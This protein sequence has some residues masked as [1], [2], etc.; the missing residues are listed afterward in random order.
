M[1][2]TK[3]NTSYQYLK[4]NDG[5]EIFAMVRELD[6][7]LELTFPMNIMCKPA[8]TGG[9][10]IHLGPFVPFTTDDTMM[11]NSNDVVVRTSITK[12]FISLYDESISVWLDMR[13][14]DTIEIKTSKQ[15]YEEQQKE[16][17]SLVKNRL[18]KMTKNDFWD[19][20]HEEEDLFDYEELPEPNETIH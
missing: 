10:T 13:E 5:K 11:I 7:K 1:P 14:N 16:L 4:F 19:D 3:D 20:Y 17:A 2:I 8:M 6:N 15:D 12:Q 9:V 18:S